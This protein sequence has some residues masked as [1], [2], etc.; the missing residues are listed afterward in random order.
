LDW[1]EDKGGLWVLFWF[2]GFVSFVSFVS[3]SFWFSFLPFPPLSSVPSIR[4]ELTFR[5]FWQFP[6]E[7]RTHKHET[8]SE[9]RERNHTRQNVQMDREERLCSTLY[10]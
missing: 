8:E 6:L 3:G 9:W 5:S 7:N 2:G 4:T 1:G 10:G